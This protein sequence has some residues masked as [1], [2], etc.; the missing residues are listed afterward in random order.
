MIYSCWS[1]WLLSRLAIYGLFML[2]TVDCSGVAHT[3]TP[4]YMAATQLVMKLIQGLAFWHHTHAGPWQPHLV[5]FGSNC[6]VGLVA[7]VEPK[8][9]HGL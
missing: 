7:E 8:Q 1:P 3:W 9:I 6:S 2:G 4:E 5:N